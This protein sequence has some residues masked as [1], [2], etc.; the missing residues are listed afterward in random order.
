VDRRISLLVLF[1]SAA[2][3]AVVACSEQPPS[4]EGVGEVV[5]EAPPPRRL[6]TG[7]DLYDEE[8]VPRESTERVAGLVMPVGLSKVG[9]LSRE[10]RHVYTSQIPPEKLLRYFGPRLTT[11]DVQRRGSMVSYR[12]AIPRGVQGG[13]VKLDVTI[14]PS[15]AHPSRVEIYERPPPPPPGV[16]IPEEEIRRHFEALQKNRE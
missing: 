4:A 14:Q 9:E 13:V 15:S 1:A 3:L 5:V 2:A 12:E 16:V 10:R 6:P 11:M 7:L 8:G